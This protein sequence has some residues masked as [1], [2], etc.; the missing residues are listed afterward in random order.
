VTQLFLQPTAT[1][2]G[3]AHL[4]VRHTA[5]CEVCCLFS[6]LLKCVAEK[7]ASHHNIRSV[8]AVCC[9]KGCV[10]DEQALR[11]QWLICHSTHEF[12]LHRPSNKGTKLLLKVIKAIIIITV[13]TTLRK[14]GWTSQWL[15]CHSQ[16]LICHGNTVTRAVWD[17]ER[18]EKGGGKSVGESV[19]NAP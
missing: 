13:T 11:E 12:E 5:T 1:D 2:L 19:G 7:A 18:S 6:R 9:R 14:G 16:W 10:A 4:W 3:H 8:Y 15:I 17:T